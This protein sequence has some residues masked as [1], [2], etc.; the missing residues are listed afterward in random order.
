MSMPRHATLALNALTAL[1]ESR[2]AGEITDAQRDALAA[3]PGWGPLA[4]AFEREPKPEWVPVADQIATMFEAQPKRLRI[5]ADYLDTSF[6]TPTGLIETMFGMLRE[7]GFTGGRVLEAGCGSG[8]FMSHTPADMAIDW[9]G[10]EADPTSADIARALHPQADIRTGKLQKITLRSG[11]FDAA[12]GNVPFAAGYV[13][14]PAYEAAP[15]HEYFIHRALD[16]VR[17]GG[18]VMVV[19]SRHV[20]DNKGALTRLQERGHLHAAVRLPAGFFR[21]EGTDVVADVLIFSRRQPGE[22]LRGWD[23][24]AEHR[25]VVEQGYMGRRLVEPVY[26]ITEKATERYAAPVEVNRYWEQHPEMVAG[27]M[28]LTGF[29]KAPLTVKADQPEAAA[30]TALDAARKCLPVYTPR[31]EHDYS[32]D[33]ADVPLADA[34]GRPEG[35]FH[36]TDDGTVAQVTGGVL[37]PIARPSAELRM[38]I[39]LRDAAEQLVAL[40]SDPDLPD[41]A[42]SPVRDQTRALYERYVAKYGPLNRGTL[43]EGKVDPE[44]GVPAF[45]WRRPTMGGFRRDPGYVLVLALEEFDQDSGAA[46]PAPIL[47]RRV[48]A[49][50]ARIESVETPAEALAVSLGEGAGIDL[51]RIAGLLGTT[52]AKARRALDGLVYRNPERGG[53]LITAAEYLSGDVVGKLEVAR[54]AAAS[55]TGYEANVEALTAI[56]PK[57]LGPTDIRAALGAT[58]ISVADIEQFISDVCQVRVKVDYTPLI[59]LWEISGH[60]YARVSPQAAL[61]YGTSKLTVLQLIEAALNGKSPIVYDTVLVS[62]GFRRVEKKVRNHEETVAAAEKISALQDRFSVWVWEDKE[63]A[64]RL[65]ALYNRRFNSHVTRVYDGSHLTFPGLSS[66]VSLWPWQKD[67]VARIMASPRSMIGHAVGA[68][69]TLEMVVSAVTMKRLGLVNKP[70]IIVP[71]HLLEQVAREA[72]QAYPTGRFLI[73]TKEDLSG[74][75]RR[76]FAARCVTGQWDA[77]VMTHGAFTS[78][79]VAPETEM[80][81]LE[82]E[83]A[84]YRELLQASNPHGNSRGAKQV[85]AMVRRFEERIAALRD[86][87]RRDDATV[88][89]DHLGIDFIACDEFHLFKRLSVGTVRAEGFSLGS[90]KRATDLLLKI[91]ALSEQRPDL[92]VFSGFTGTPWSNTLVETFVWQ[93]YLQPD[94]LAEADMASLDAWGAMFVRWETNVEIA[95]DGSGFRLHRRPAG[96]Q[97]VPEL[98]AMLDEVADLLPSA[99]LDLPRPNAHRINVSVPAGPAQKAA[100]ADLVVRA[101]QLRAGKSEL[102]D[103]RT[104]N[105]LL[106]CGDGRRLALDPRLVGIDEDSAK[107]AVVADQ[108]AARWNAHRDTLLPGSATPGVFQLVLCDQGTPKPQDNQTYGRLRALL[109]ARGLPSGSVR[110]VHE[111][112]TDKAR[113]ALFAACR[114]GSVAVLLGSTEK[115]GI[116]TNVQ[117]RLKAIHHVD[118]PWRPSDIEQRDGRGIRPG[119]L[120]DDV[121]LLRYVTEGT[122]DAYMWQTLERKARFIAQMFRRTITEREIDDIADIVLTYGEVKALAAGNPMLLEQSQ[123]QATVK[124][125]RVMRA[126]HLQGVNAARHEAEQMTKSATQDRRLAEHCTTAAAIAADNPPPADVLDL[127]ARAASNVRTRS[128]RDFTWRGLTV[129]YADPTPARTQKTGPL[130]SMLPFEIKHT[131]TTVATVMIKRSDLRAGDAVAAAKLHDALTAALADLPRRAADLLELAADREQRAA[132]AKAAAETAVFGQQAELDAALSKLAAITSAIEMAAEATEVAAAQAAA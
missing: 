109:H 27:R 75:A 92:P 84:K 13:Y 117:R 43:T 57:P 79:P 22:Q 15:L 80:A 89:F 66:T 51:D 130:P 40:E 16:A 29:D 82:E 26:R 126:V 74:T 41:S 88:L 124:R 68:G 20:M 104:D 97:N 32:S 127:L 100:V 63:R 91:T 83:K 106:I 132:Q 9:V 95:P 61:A 125:L 12:I 101:E 87:A 52:P 86:D 114:D 1:V 39:E 42:I 5:A 118:A 56:Q 81:W 2:A 55:D 4:G 67:A 76:L 11:E 62:D 7:A 28:L 119:N 93:T 6:Y 122:F 60:K 129:A 99:D 98:R 85:A 108:I 123:T 8:R 64:D 121:D 115:V 45:S 77:V 47:L 111:A 44:T 48:N 112:T 72:Q 21:G 107:L 10:I 69:K 54:R 78:L 59:A 49:R 70:L 71:N 113:A 33:L 30:A 120:N 102:P 65:T 37:V 131:W 58:W 23:N 34:D 17:P 18:L 19:T 25:A 36:L 24:A 116:G 105:M 3:W 90:S 128:S 103:G 38:L 96:I 73:A 110:F 50:P 94:R 14:D 46:G 35:S 53:Q 31:V